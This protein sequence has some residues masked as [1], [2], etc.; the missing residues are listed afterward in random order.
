MENMFNLLHTLED[1]KK[2]IERWRFRMPRKKKHECGKAYYNKSRKNWFAPYTTIDEKTGREVLHKKSFPTEEEANQFLV[3]LE[4][5]K[6]SSIYVKHNGI[7][8]NELMKSINE[9]KLKF[10]KLR[11]QQYGKNARIIEA[12]EK[13]PI[14]KKEISEITADELQ[15]YFNSLKDYS[16]SYMQKYMMQF[17]QAFNYAKEKGYISVNPMVDVYKPKS[18]KPNKFIRALEIEEQQALTEYLINKSIAEEPYKNAL[19]AQMYLGLRI[20]EALALQYDD[21]DT[22]KHLVYVHQTL[23][24]DAEERVIL[25]PF[26]KSSAGVRTIPIPPNLQKE[27]EMQKEL[28]KNN[29]D[30]F[31]FLGKTGSMA[32]PRTVNSVLKRILTKNFKIT[33]ISTH[34]LRHTFGTRCI[35]AGM[36]PVALQRLMGHADVGITLNT[37]TSILSKFKNE[38]FG[39]VNN[40]YEENGLFH[41]KQKQRKADKEMEK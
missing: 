14:G 40:Y 4:Y 32:D 2:N 20:G 34:S 29:K 18:N 33:D 8:L 12:I 9:R 3:E 22:K 23:S 25:K 7:P 37:Y 21:I 26:P 11:E 17:T 1:Q 6:N 31:L 36:Q 10:N 13:L 35:E 24:R 15:A 41:N 39:K 28:S 5:K 16:N 38:E 30:Q 19:L 27:F